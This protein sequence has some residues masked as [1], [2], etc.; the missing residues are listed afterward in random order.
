MV[1]LVAFDLDGTLLR[2]DTVCEGIAR[3]VS[4]SSLGFPNA[5]T[6]RCACGTRVVVSPGT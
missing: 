4:T 3:K 5:K 1:G 6:F 2:G